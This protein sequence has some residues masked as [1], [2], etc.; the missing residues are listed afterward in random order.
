VQIRRVRKDE[1]ACAPSYPA[2]P[3][4]RDARRVRDALWRGC[5]STRLCVALTR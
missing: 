4:R 3:A 1:G 2:R 5:A